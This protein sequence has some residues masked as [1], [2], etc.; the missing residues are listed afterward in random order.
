[1]RP[2]AQ[3]ADAGL[4]LAGEV[5]GN[6]AR[7]AD[8]RLVTPLYHR[9]YLVLREKIEAGEFGGDA[10]LPGE[11]AMCEMF[12]V[13]R[14]TIRRALKELEGEKLVTRMQGSGTFAR[15]PVPVKAVSGSMADY[16]QYRRG[17]A[18]I[19]DATVISVGYVAPPAL[20]RAAMGCGENANVHMSVRIRSFRSTPFLHLTVYT[21]A[22]I[23]RHYTEQQLR[24]EPLLSLLQKYV[25]VS[26]A[27]Q[28]VSATLASPDVAALLQVE[29]GAPLTKVTYLI[30]DEQER[31]VEYVVSFARPD[32][33]QLRSTL[34]FD[35]AIPGA[36]KRRR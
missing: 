9:I 24:T 19:S 15:A 6:P 31:I 12:G 32:L 14:I 36:A 10:P 8:R 17:I 35:E 11:A 3:P 29:I 7:P 34:R 30:S 27:E 33:Y 16:L 21:L 25:K 20:I 4:P 13:S 28:I 18:E 2:P 5:S 1:M 22:E 26:A 23:G